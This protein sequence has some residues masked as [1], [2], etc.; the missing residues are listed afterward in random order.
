MAFSLY[1]T[2]CSLLKIWNLNKLTGVMIVFNFQG[3]RSWPM[4]PKE[5]TPTHISISEKVKPMDVE[6]LEK[7]D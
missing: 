5:T 2:F 1:V 6:F 4:K 3:A 7:E